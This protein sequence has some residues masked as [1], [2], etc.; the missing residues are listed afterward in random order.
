MNFFNK[1]P[2]LITFSRSIHTSDDLISELRLLCTWELRINES[3]VE[4]W[5]VG[6]LR[7]TQPVCRNYWDHEDL[8]VR[9]R[10]HHLIASWLPR[11]V[12][13]AHSIC[14][15]HLRLRPPSGTES[16]RNQPLHRYV[17]HAVYLH[18]SFATQKID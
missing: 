8:I 14:P 3:D 4:S 11:I 17:A 7:A 10:Y 1:I 12:N 9:I 2:F 18:Y 5:I 6:S 15:V 13:P 16:V